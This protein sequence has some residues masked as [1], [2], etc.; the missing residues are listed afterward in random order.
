MLKNDYN[1]RKYTIKAISNEV[2]FKKSE[3]FS[4]AFRKFIGITPLNFIN[5]LNNKV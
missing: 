3:S 4:R 1:Y 5:E 2:G